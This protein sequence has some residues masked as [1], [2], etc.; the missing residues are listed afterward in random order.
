MELYEKGDSKFLWFDFTV[1]G[2][3]YRGSTKETNPKRAEAIAAIKLAKVLEGN[4]PLPKRAPVLRVFSERFLS[5]VENAKL[6]PKSK[7]YYKDGWR[8]LAETQIA[9]M[10]LDVITND[11]LDLVSFPG[12]ASN[13]QASNSQASNGPLTV[14]TARILPCPSPPKICTATRPTRPTRCCC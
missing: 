14:T 9:G 10:R 8:L 13:S 5:W 1:A 7:D 2:K 4:A 12:S 3:R 11:D 6:E